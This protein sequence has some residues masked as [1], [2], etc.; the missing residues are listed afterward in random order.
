MKK[1]NK[2]LTSALL[3]RFRMVCSGRYAPAQTIRKT[4]VAK[5]F[6]FVQL[7]ITINDIP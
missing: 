5:R 4:A 1:K 2:F 7:K 3:N 6:T